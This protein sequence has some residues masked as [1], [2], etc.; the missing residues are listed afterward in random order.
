[1]TAATSNIRLDR[2]D[3]GIAVLDFDKPGSS[4]N[5]FDRKTL[6]ELGQHLDA[7][8]KDASIKGLVLASAKDGIFIAGADLLELSR[9]DAAGIR[10]I[11]SLGQQLFA[12]VAALRIPTAAAIHGACLGGGFEIALACDWRVAT[13][14]RAT[15]IGL[16]ECNL[17]IL[18]AWG[19]STRLPRLVGL[20]AALGAILGAEQMAPKKALKIGAVDAVVPKEHVVREA[21]KLLARGKAHRKARA[22]VNNPLTAAILRSKIGRDLARKTGG[23]YPAFPRAL[24]VVTRGASGSIDASLARELSA[25]CDLTATDACRSL[26]GVFFLQ[27]RSKRITVPGAPSVDSLAPVERVAVIGAGV[28]GAGIAQWCAARGHDVLLKDIGTEPLAR[29]MKTIDDLIRPLVKRRKLTQVEGRQ[30]VDRIRPTTEDVPL[31][32]TDLVVEAA[33]E[34]M[35]IKQKIF[36]RLA[37]L[38]TPATIL[39]TNTSA[40]SVTELAAA[41]PHPERVVGIHFFNP[42]ARMQLV[43]VVAAKQTSPEV[44]A[45]A[46]RFVQQIGKMPVVVADSPGFVVNRILTPYLVEAGR[47]FAEGMPI[48]AVDRAMKAFGMPMGPLRLIDEVGGDV[49][50]HVAKHQAAHYPG[51]IEVPPLL[52]RMA[53]DGLLGRKTGAGF[54]IYPKKG[55]SQVNDKVRAMAGAGS[56]AT[57]SREDA[58]ARMALLMVNESARCLEERVAGAAEDIDFAM[59]MGTGFAPFRGGPLRYADSLGSEAVVAKLRDLTARYGPRFEPCALLQ[60]MAAKKRSFYEDALPRAATNAA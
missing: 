24:D 20:P 11:G 7:I 12:R 40:L 60:D 54:Y 34:R 38:S 9:L 59:I 37:E 53:A 48:D 15:K 23:H 56:G 44:L 8:E 43:E 36:Q 55:R 17:G 57:V 4:A 19:G 28:M 14:D 45:R 30:I 58:T 50:G 18:P 27:E 51:L 2:R 52:D 42:V 5:T 6:E 41:V 49:A 46:V 29:G 21:V 13:D 31:V 25:L 1:M 22:L 3:D 47:L 10:A 35:D 32:H 33:V 39:A 16:P 26:V